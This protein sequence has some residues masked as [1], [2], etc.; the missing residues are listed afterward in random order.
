[1]LL[2][3]TVILYGQAAVG[4]QAIEKARHALPFMPGFLKMAAD[5]SPTT[6]V[7]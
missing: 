1:L 3:E 7:D 6:K 2:F 5:I 4:K